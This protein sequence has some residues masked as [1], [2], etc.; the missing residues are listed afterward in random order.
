MAGTFTASVREN[1]GRQYLIVEFRHPLRSDPN[2]R[3]G[4]KIRKGLG[5]ADRNEAET[6][7]AQLNDLLRDESLWSVGARPEAVR[8][9]FD[10][11]VIEIFYA[12]LEPSA[13]NAKA[14]RDQAIPLPDRESGWARQLLI[15]APGGGKST[16]IRQLMGTHPE[17]E[18]FPPTSANRTT[19]FPFEIVFRDGGYAAAVTFL[20][21]H[22]TRFEIEESVSAA[23]VRAATD[24]ID[25]TARDFLEQPDMRFRLRY[26][27]GD[28]RASETTGDDDPYA[29]PDA[30][31]LIEDPESDVDERANH[32]KIG[33]FVKRIWTLARQYRQMLEEAHGN[34]DD[35]EVE[36][37]AA[38]LDLIQS[39][40][41]ADDAYAAI[42]SDI[43]EDLRERFTIVTVG[44]FEKNT[45]GW[46]RAWRLDVGTSER[47]EFFTSLRFFAGIAASH[48]G[49]LL[50]PLVNAIRVAGPFQPAWATKCPKL[51][52]FDTEGLGHK[53]DASAD[54]PDHLVAMFAET[55][56]IVLV[57]SGKSA[58][59]F[60]VGKA[61]EALVSAGQTKKTCVAF[62]HMDVVHGP[63]LR[64]RAKYEHAFNN[65]RNIVENQLAKSLPSDV[66]R[67]VTEHL[68]RNVFY[69]G[70]IDGAEATPAY[71][72][73]H[74]LLTRLESAAPKPQKVIGFPKYSTDNLVLSIREAAEAFR[75]P[76]RARLGL[77]THP[78]EKAYAWQSIKA[79][80]RRYAEGFDD[81]Y[82]L[83]PASNLLTAL[84]GAI[85]RFLEG[86]TAWEGRLTTEE[87]RDIID[88]IKAAATNSLA[89]LSGRRLREQPQPQWQTAWG[90]RG[91]RSTFDRRTSVESIYARW[92]PIPT[93]VGDQVAQEF[94]DDVKGKVIA[95][96][97]AIR[98]AAESQAGQ[99]GTA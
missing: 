65:L 39:E 6:L 56:S 25:R 50:T 53:A 91:F 94:L 52:L 38:A 20:S 40:A 76:W 80:T 27:L 28:Y 43:L 89:A 59:D 64:G 14:S 97:D 21:E 69:L 62:T 2:G 63:N 23:I 67:F 12:E 85:S 8:R 26:S 17:R 70:K 51:V 9:G 35:M 18:A 60:S 10:Q 93:S 90:L 72:E 77:D 36:H 92:V 49:R 31:G 33:A 32:D 71:P 3:R 99:H 74:R 46:P 42:V 30:E 7:V 57:H 4:R 44:Q 87:K 47:K 73:L 11:R 88:R 37:R 55:D 78:Q 81:G 96:I 82:P 24:D 54:L 15:G 61:L 41:E 19:T 29:E 86:P 1:P 68:E 34:I 83:R 98:H 16:L 58:M 95:A 13:R 22:E 84:S 48:W 5:T 45:T 75:L 66:V 79:M